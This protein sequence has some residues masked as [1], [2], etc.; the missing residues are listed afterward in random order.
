MRI[1][2]VTYGLPYPP[3]SGGRIHD[4]NIIKNISRHHSVLL[5]SLLENS[6]EVHS[7]PMLEK[8]CELVYV[9]LKKHRSVWQ[10]FKGVLRCLLT[11]Q[12]I[13]T[14]DYYYS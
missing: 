11:N 12:P 2:Y 9:V 8:Y 3:D 6:K 5:I 4:F 14:H 1:L 10:H 7:I 13:A